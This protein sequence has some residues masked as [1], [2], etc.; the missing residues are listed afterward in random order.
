MNDRKFLIFRIFIITL[1][2]FCLIWIEYK[3]K[4]IIKEEQKVVKEQKNEITEEIVI[5]A[6]KVYISNNQDYFAD[7]LKEDLEIRINTDDLVKTRL[8]NNNKNFKGY[9]S[10][11]KDEFTYNKI[12]DFLINNISDKDYEANSNNEK[13][14]Y[15]IKYY[16]KAED[17]K[18]YI[19]YNGKL[20]RIIGITNSND[21]KVISTENFTEEKWGKSG[22]INYLKDNDNVTEDG[23][24][25]IFY[26]GFVRSETKDVPSIIKNEKRNNTYTVGNPRYIGT[27]SYV[28]VSDIVNASSA[29]KYNNIT[30]IN[31]ETCNSYLLNMLGN[32][33]TSTSLEN[34]QVYK[35]N[36]KYEVI[37]SKLEDNI[38]IK[39][40]QYISG[41]S[42]YNCGNGT[43]D[44]PYEIK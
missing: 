18:N 32:T 33:Y 9:V 10:V 26:V 7:L 22:N 19:K 17:P 36:D 30:N 21:L 23:Y 27:Y 24:K 20:Y 3:Q 14:A 8:I 16:Y 13:D 39:K 12:N 40:V 34:D 44:N 4:E 11:Y 28:N 41:L 31:K 37:S 25:G 38:L 5:D 2:A 6:A 29:C 43:F 15:D 42:E 35:V 1:A